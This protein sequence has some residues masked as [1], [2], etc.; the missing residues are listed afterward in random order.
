MASFLR[1]AAEVVADRDLEIVG[2]GVT[3]PSDALH[4][5]RGEETLDQVQPR[6]A[7]VCEIQLEARMFFRPGPYLWRLVGGVA[8]EHDV[9][10]SGYPG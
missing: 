7:G 9:D 4:R 3:A 6:C 8:V 2:A 10:G 5:E 1:C